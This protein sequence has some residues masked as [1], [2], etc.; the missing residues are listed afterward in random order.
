MTAELIIATMYKV[1]DLKKD[2]K[3]P[4]LSVPSAQLFVKL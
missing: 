3:A 1:F 2:R 4:T